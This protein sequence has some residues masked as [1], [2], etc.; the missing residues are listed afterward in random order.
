MPCYLIGLSR[1]NLQM[2]NLKCEKNM[3]NHHAQHVHVK[4]KKLILTI[5]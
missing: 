3:P 2:S 5:L 1:L 4:K